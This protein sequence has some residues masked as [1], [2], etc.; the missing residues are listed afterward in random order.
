MIQQS[1]STN[2]NFKYRPN[3]VKSS[4]SASFR[5][6]F[7]NIWQLRYRIYALIV[8]ASLTPLLHASTKNILPGQIKLN[9][10]KISSTNPLFSIV[11]QNKLSN[12][13]YASSVMLVVNKFDYFNQNK[14]VGEVD[15]SLINILG[16]K[17]AEDI[18]NSKSKPLNNLIACPKNPQ[19]LNYLRYG[20]YNIN[21]PIVY[22]KLTDLFQANPDGTANTSKPIEEDSS[23]GPLSNPIQR[24]LVDGIVHIAFTSQP[25]EIGNS[26]IVGHSSNFTSVISDYNTIFKPIERVSKPGEEFTI[27]DSCG[28]ELKFVVFETKDILEK[29]VN[30]AY[31]TF[32]DRRVVTLQTSILEFVPGVG[33]Y[34]TKRWLTRGELVIE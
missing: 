7:K 10:A 18:K 15:S 31:K 22:S 29:D 3:E 13:N 21:T 34:P 17:A 26:Y 33:F 19:Q 8:L 23:Q 4:F 14:G 32:G 6:F 25:G 1:A 20:Q 24:L 2:H 9:K 11:K 16:N 30:E 5:I 27:W 12:E 28:R